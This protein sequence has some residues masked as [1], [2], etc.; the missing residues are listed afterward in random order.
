MKAERTHTTNYINTFIET[1]E[2]SPIDKAEIPLQKGDEKTVAGLQ[3]DL[4]YEHPYKHTSDDVI[5]GVYA[6]KNKIGRSELAGEREKF[7]SKGQPCMRCSPLGKRYGWGVHSDQDG[8]IAIYPIESEEYKK[9]SEDENLK[10]TKAMRS[11]RA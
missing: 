9:F 4:I 8:K 5:F 3:F 10:H 1:A 6:S 7:F 2:D 11:K